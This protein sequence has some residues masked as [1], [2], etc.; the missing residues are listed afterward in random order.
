MRKELHHRR[1]YRRQR[2]H[3]GHLSRPRTNYHRHRRRNRQ[4]HRTPRRLLVAVEKMRQVPRQ[5]KSLGET[6]RKLSS[7]HSFIIFEKKKM[8]SREID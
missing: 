3:R 5:M 7:I 4:S 2:G 6:G 1:R 8:R